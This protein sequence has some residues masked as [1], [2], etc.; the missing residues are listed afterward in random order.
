MVVV[1]VSFFFFFFFKAVMK[2]V[3]QYHNRLE[4]GQQRVIGI[5][6]FQ[7]FN[8]IFRID[9]QNLTFIIQLRSTHITERGKKGREEREHEQIKFGN[10]TD[11]KTQAERERK[12]EGGREGE[13]KEKE[14]KRKKIRRESARETERERGRQKDRQRKRKEDRKKGKRTRANQVWEPYRCEDT[15]GESERTREEG[16]KE[17]ERGR[18]EATEREKKR[19]T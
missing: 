15:G 4:T 2:R 1:V 14:R 17:R 7:N 10:P 16:W 13:K 9:L 19:E 5:E 12:G 3:G 18:E 11:A 8:R 6:S